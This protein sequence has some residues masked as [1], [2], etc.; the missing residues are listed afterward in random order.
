MDVEKGEQGEVWYDA[1]RSNTT[2][3][4]ASGLQDAPGATLGRPA[5]ARH[6]R[7][8]G[9][10]GKEEAVRWDL[11]RQRIMGVVGVVNGVC[12]KRENLQK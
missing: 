2:S 7:G 1:T 11:G 3:T 8:K 9:S 6:W 12:G 5:S 10:R 4:A